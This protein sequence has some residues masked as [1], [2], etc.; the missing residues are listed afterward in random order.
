MMK[1]DIAELFSCEG[2]THK[3]G[4]VKM[5]R[6]DHSEDIISQASGGVVGGNELRFA[7][8]PETAACDSIHV[9]LGSKLGSE[10]VEDMS[11]IA[12]AGEQN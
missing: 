3:N 12:H 10:L 6:S 8:R 7:R 1:A 9:V 2:V 4:A 5:E 11:S